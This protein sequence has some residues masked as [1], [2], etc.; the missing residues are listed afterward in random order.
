MRAENRRTS[1]SLGRWKKSDKRLKYRTGS[2]GHKT[3][4][5]NGGRGEKAP[6]VLLIEGTITLLVADVRLLNGWGYI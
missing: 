6:V 1:A 2:T 4:S 5:Q 3:F